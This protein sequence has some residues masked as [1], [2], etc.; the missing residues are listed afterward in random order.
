MRQLRA[1]LALILTVVL[2]ALLFAAPVEAQGYPPSTTTTAP[3]PTEDFIDAGVH[4]EGDTI[5]IEAC[6]FLP[7]TTVTLEL[8][9]ADAGVD[10]VDARGCVVIVIKILD[11]D[12]VASGD[13]Q[14]ILGAIGSQL[15]HLAQQQ[16]RAQ[17]TLDGRP[18]EA[19]IGVNTLI[20]RGTGANTAPRRV[21]A[22]FTIARRATPGSPADPGTGGGGTPT[23][24]RNTPNL[25]A[26]TGPAVAG[27][28]MVGVVLVGVGLGLTRASK[29]RRRLA[30]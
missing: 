28:L 29:R 2:A 17:I 24:G 30:A 5:T 10:T 4:V 14:R 18:M 9:G 11:T 7:G 3:Q 6:F 12:A 15:I 26:R 25:F 1:A 27:M 8:N 13:G 19:L 20:I 23:R 16:A 21:T 22:R